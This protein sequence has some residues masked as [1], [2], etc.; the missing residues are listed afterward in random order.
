MIDSLEFYDNSILLGTKIQSDDPILPKTFYDNS[1]LLGT[2]IRLHV[3]GSDDKFYDNSILL[4]TKIDTD[5]DAIS[6]CFTIT[7]FF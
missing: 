2:K 1:I 4:G 7:Q 5:N 3:H 6:Q